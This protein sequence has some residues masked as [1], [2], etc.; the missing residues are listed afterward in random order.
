MADGIF[1]SSDAVRAALARERLG[2]AQLIGNLGPGG[3]GALG[4]LMAGQGIGQLFGGV[5]PRL[6]RAQR[7]E[8][9]GREMESAGIEP[10]N[11]S[12]PREVY[13]RM[14][15][16]GFS[17]RDALAAFQQ[18]MEASRVAAQTATERSQGRYAAARA[19]I[20][21]SQAP[22]AGT[23]AQAEAQQAVF[24]A[25]KALVEART[26]PEREAAALALDQARRASA[27]ASADSSRASANRTRQAAALDIVKAGQDAE[28]LAA[29]SVKDQL[30]SENTL[31]DDY[32]KAVSRQVETLEHFNNVV[33]SSRIGSA[34]ADLAML[35]SFT[36]MQDPASVAREGE[37]Q[38]T[39]STVSAVFPRI[40]KKAKALLNGEVV[41]L[42]ESERQEIFKAARSLA[43]TARGTLKK[44]NETF[45]DLAGRAGADPQAVVITPSSEFGEQAADQPVAEFQRAMPGLTVNPAGGP[46]GPSPPV[47]PGRVVD[48]NSLPE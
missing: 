37:V 36:K 31:R 11:P 2:Q 43:N 5:D 40:A 26:A 27:L 39:I 20:A 42:T 3:L 19:D 4:G 18:A 38:A 44:R 28:K 7:L 47:G 6:Q 48:F 32:V 35:I 17:Q 16:G 8:Q 33:S 23:Q 29:E 46:G 41:L 34:P 14:V 21:E 25:Q 45:S 10:E 24:D 13:R 30:A 9:I 12:F 15:A 1:G 22:F